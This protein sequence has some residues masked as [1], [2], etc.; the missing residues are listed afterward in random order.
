MSKDI[1]SLQIGFTQS[2][3]IMWKADVS[4]S[5]RSG[6]FFLMFVRTMLALPRRVIQI[7]LSLTIA[8][9]KRGGEKK[10][11]STCIVVTSVHPFSFLRSETICNNFL[12][13]SWRSEP[14]PHPP[15]K[16]LFFFFLDRTWSPVWTS[17]GTG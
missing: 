2:N 16:T 9:E 15:V 13:H 11:F 14:H 12:Y 3:I 10:I 4:L 17:A 1:L 6:V 8:R 7:L 5:E